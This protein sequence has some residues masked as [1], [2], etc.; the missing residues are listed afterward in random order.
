MSL[1]EKRQNG[2][3]M[4]TQNFYEVLYRTSHVTKNPTVFTYLCDVRTNWCFNIKFCLLVNEIK[5]QF[6]IMT[7]TIPTD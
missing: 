6:K 1:T 4:K 2:I 5:I 3:N 7:S